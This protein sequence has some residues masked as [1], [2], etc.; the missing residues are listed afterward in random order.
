MQCPLYDS[1]LQPQNVYIFFVDRLGKIWSHW[2]A[3]IA[4]SGPNMEDLPNVDKKKKNSVSII[5]IKDFHRTKI[6]I[7]HH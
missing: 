5:F 7:F 2:Q 6:K 4:V 3:S 1:K